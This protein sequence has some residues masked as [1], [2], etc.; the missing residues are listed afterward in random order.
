M[1]GEVA[2]RHVI[3]CTCTVQLRAVA[4]V[5]VV[6]EPRREP[7]LDDAAI[8]DHVVGHLGE[9]V[10]PDRDSAESPSCN[11]RYFHPDLFSGF[12]ADR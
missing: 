2:A 5:V 9:H 6:L 1:A 7:F 10:F 4:M 11:R 3:A 8:V 12:F